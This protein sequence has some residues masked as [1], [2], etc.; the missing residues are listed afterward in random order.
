MKISIKINP[1]YDKQVPKLSE[2]EYTRYYNPL[3][4]MANQ[5]QYYYYNR[6]HRILLL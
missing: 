2:Q 5:V 6:D 4:T 1:K 3:G